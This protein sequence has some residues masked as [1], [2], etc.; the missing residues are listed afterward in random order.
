MMDK[1][2][3]STH[4]SVLLLIDLQVNLA[5]AMDRQWFGRVEKNIEMIIDACSALGIPMLMTEQYKKGL[6][7]T[8]DKIR[9]KLGGNYRPV[10][11][12]EFSCYANPQF[13]D[14]LEHSGKKYVII[15]GIEAHVCILQT[16][17]DLL[18]AGYYIHVISD[19][20]CSRYI[21]DYENAISYM[22]DAGAVITTAET[23]L[24]QLLQKAGTPDFKS[25]SP[26]FKNR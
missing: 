12:M 20:I 21:N 22:R 24:F 14:A 8:V 10:E 19:A 17:M 11:K 4:N 9:N 16:A 18:K 25:I 23:I 13:H 7:I 15:C 1:L 5:A 2:R 3:I 6:G 26:L